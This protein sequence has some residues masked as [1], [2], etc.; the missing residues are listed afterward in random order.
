MDEGIQKLIDEQQILINKFCLEI[1]KID[2][3]IKNEQK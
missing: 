3:N 1:V 2:G